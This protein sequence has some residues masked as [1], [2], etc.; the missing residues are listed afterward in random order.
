VINIVGHPEQ[1][2]NACN[3]ISS[4]DTAANTDGT[5]RRSLHCHPQRD[6]RGTRESPIL[7][8]TLALYRTSQRYRYLRLS[9]GVRQTTTVSA[10]ERQLWIPSPI[11]GCTRTTHKRALWGTKAY[12]YNWHSAGSLGRPL[13]ML[14]Y[15]YLSQIKYA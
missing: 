9:A 5:V 4:L 12:R 13:P 11:T 10:V 8:E 7:I 15:K 2:C 1:K 14:K 3:V 6:T